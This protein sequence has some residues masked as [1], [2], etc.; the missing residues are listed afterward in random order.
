[1]YLTQRLIASRL[2]DSDQ[3]E[4]GGVWR[5]V[6]TEVRKFKVMNTA[7]ELQHEF[8]AL[9]NQLTYVAQGLGQVSRMTRSNARRSSPLYVHFTSRCT[10]ARIPRPSHSLRPQATKILCFARQ[11]H[12]LVATFMGQQQGT[13]YNYLFLRTPPHFDS[14][15]VTSTQFAGA[16]SR[17]QSPPPPIPQDTPEGSRRSSFDI[18]VSPPSRPE[19][20]ELNIKSPQ[21]PL[22]FQQTGLYQSPTAESERSIRDA[23]DS[24]G[25]GSPYLALA[26]RNVQHSSESLPAR[27]PTPDSDTSWALP[28]GR[29]IRLIN[30]EQIPRYVNKSHV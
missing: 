24:R 29:T 13:S 2:R 3:F 1:M 6:L 9:W 15:H 23:S 19:T 22:S 20:P 18:R 7:P 30:S 27:A 28:R 21:S 10:K 16:P 26:H 5:N 4:R 11:P 17:S 14:S 8:C 25:F 12:T